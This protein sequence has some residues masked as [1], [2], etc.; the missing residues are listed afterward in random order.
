MKKENDKENYN[1]NII[2]KLDQNFHNKI[3][4]ISK[5]CLIE[6]LFSTSANLFERFIQDARRTIIE[7]NRDENIL[8]QSHKSIYE[9]IKDNNSDM[10]YKEMKK[11]MQNIRT[12][13]SKEHDKNTN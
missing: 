11:H 4:N 3:A 5:N 13:Y 12:S 1:D 9:A 8:Y 2:I 7:N 10:A 6:S